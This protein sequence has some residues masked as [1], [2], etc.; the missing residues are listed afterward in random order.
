MYLK[1]PTLSTI[2]NTETSALHDIFAK[3][4]LPGKTGSF[5]FDTFVSTPKVF[6]EHPLRELHELAFH[7]VNKHGDTVDFNE[8]DHSIVLE[9]VEAVERLERL[10]VQ[11]SQ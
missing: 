6:N 10:N 9:I 5:V 1:C 11:M 3:I 7:F 2:K 8:M 4:L